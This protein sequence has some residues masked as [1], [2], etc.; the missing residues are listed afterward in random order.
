MLNNTVYTWVK[1][2]LSG[3]KRGFGMLG[4]LWL[5]SGWKWEGGCGSRVDMSGGWSGVGRSW[6]MD[7]DC[8]SC[9]ML[10]LGGVVKGLEGEI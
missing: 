1:V 7:E 5:G 9:V 2:S 4:H 6:G 10:K 3:T 8:G